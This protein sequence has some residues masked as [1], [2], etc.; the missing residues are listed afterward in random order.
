M[1]I[2]ITGATGFVGRRLAEAL[3]AR[4]D[5]VVAFTRDPARARP[6]FSPG[7]DT[8]AW[9]PT[10]VPGLAVALAGCD[11][12][13]HLAGEPVLGRR[14]TSAQKQRI[15]ES[16]VA[17]TRALVDALESDAARPSVLVSASA[18]GYYGDRGAETLDESATSG[19]DFLAGVCREWE[20]RARRAFRLGI[21]TVIVRIGIV[22]GEGGGALET[23]LPPFKLG[24]GGPIG[25][26]RQYMSWIHVDDLVAMLRFAID[27]P[28][29]EGVVNA[30]APEPVTN[31]VFSKVLGRVLHRPAVLPV[32]PLALKLALGGVSEVLVG[33]QRVLPKRALAAGFRFAHPDL[34][35]AL[36]GLVR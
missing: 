18:V 33:G 7:V 31:R 21:R 15:R 36:S 34:R 10:D 19:D 9:D 32:P 26:G 5:S 6:T 2:A 27:T 22:L 11:A 1:K 12:V 28:A 8:V 30:T 13:V 4:G 3:V 20:E 29:L 25:H 16:R 14:W 35:A 23:M 17:G 24:I